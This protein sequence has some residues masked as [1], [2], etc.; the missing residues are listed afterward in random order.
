M[1]KIVW[2][3]IALIWMPWAEGGA[4]ELFFGAASGERLQFKLYWMG[5]LAGEA[6]LQMESGPQGSYVV[7]STLSSSGAA[8]LVRAIDDRFTAE[9]QRHGFL[10]SAR[11]Y[12]KEQQRGSQSKWSR[13]QFDREL[14][15]V[16]RTRRGSEEQREE[17]LPIAVE[18]EQVTDPFSSFYAVRAWPELFPNRRLDR[19]AVEGEKVHCLSIAVGGGHMLATKLGELAVFPVR[20]TVGN[21]EMFRNRGPIVVWLTDD[22]RR[23]PVQVEAQLAIGSVVAELVAYED[24]LG[25]SKSVQQGVGEKR[26]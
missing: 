14:R 6:T 24:G 5:V 22:I 10:W 18:S 7:R 9:G 21:S 17:R 1:N 13:Y 26:E 8:R 12:L 3:A 19:W 15:Q 2:V 11:R 23:I 4:A 16:V 20:I 25:G